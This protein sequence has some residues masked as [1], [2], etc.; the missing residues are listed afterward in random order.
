MAEDEA[1]PPEA[2]VAQPITAT[3]LPPPEP[4]PYAPM[5]M[6]VTIPGGAY[7]VQAGTF[8]TQ[9]GADRAVARLA[10]AGGAQIVPLQRNGATLYRVVVGS[11]PDPASAG[12]TR[13]RVIAMGFGD[14][15]V[16]GAH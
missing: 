10:S 3:A 6:R 4:A 14:A 5:A 13:A 7:S 2:P 1:G 16:V 11:F 12:E 9:S 8:A 15:Q